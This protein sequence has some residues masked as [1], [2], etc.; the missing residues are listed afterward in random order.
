LDLPLRRV[1]MNLTRLHDDLGNV[2]G[3]GSQVEVVA[4]DSN[5]LEHVINAH[6][7]WT[8]TIPGSGVL[9]LGQKEGGPDIGATQA[10]AKKAGT[11]RG[12]RTFNHTLGPLPQGRGIIHGGTGVFAR[13]VGSFRE[14]NTLYQVPAEGDLDGSADYEFTL[15][16]A[17]RRLDQQERVRVKERHFEIDL[18]TDVVYETGGSLAKARVYPPGLGM[19][20]DAALAGVRVFMAKLR[21]ERGDVVGLAGASRVQGAEANV[22]VDTAQWTL[23]LPG[24]GTL[25]AALEP[26]TLHDGTANAGFFGRTRGVITGGTGTYAHTTG[27][28]RERWPGAGSSSITLEATLVENF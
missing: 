3:I 5:P 27:F 22:S 19:L 2:V 18:E 6:T 13:M 15:L 26:K 24:Y 20:N 11:W 8:W 17:L 7:D 16:R 9:F 21:D 28:V 10:E 4:L 25:Y 1:F 12:R 23:Q 14:L